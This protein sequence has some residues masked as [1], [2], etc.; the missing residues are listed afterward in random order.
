MLYIFDTT[1]PEETPEDV[2]WCLE[3]GTLLACDTE[4]QRIH[5]CETLPEE[6]HNPE[7]LHAIYTSWLQDCSGAFVRPP[8]L[9]QCLGNTK[10]IV[11]L[12]GGCVTIE[13]DDEDDDWQLLW[14]PT[15]LT[16]RNQ[17]RSFTLAWA[18]LYRKKATRIPS[19]AESRPSTP[20][21][22]LNEIHEV[23]ITTHSAHSAHPEIQLEHPS[24]P[25]PA[26]SDTDWL[27]ELT[28]IPAPYVNSQTLRLQDPHQE[29]LRKRIRDARI[30]AK[31]AR[32]RAERLAAHYERRYGEWPEE[33]AE[34]AETDVGSDSAEFDDL[35]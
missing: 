29:K 6:A 18:P 20:T 22:E 25:L 1:L 5:I 21:P 16:L 14:V 8:T 27:Q 4:E 30:R 35:N 3:G 28:D 23:Q 33:D 11:D 31:L 34:E 10:S 32:Y 19:F 17:P 2:Q 24:R 12:S 9:T 26:H 13:P 15:R 7:R